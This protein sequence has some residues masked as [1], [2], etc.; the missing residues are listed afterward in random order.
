MNTGILAVDP[1]SIGNRPTLRSFSDAGHSVEQHT[2]GSRPI[3]A[4]LGIA[5]LGR[6]ADVAQGDPRIIATSRLFDAYTDCA[7]SGMPENESSPVTKRQLANALRFI[8]GLSRAFPA[9]DISIDPSGDIWFEWHA[10]RFRT[11][12]IAVCDGP[13]LHYSALIGESKLHGTERSGGSL[14]PTFV[15]ILRQIYQRNA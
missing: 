12:A 9:P 3:Q 4:L 5:H 1:A 15:F 2:S 7:D 8:S 13:D 11:F 14:A 6:D 10:R